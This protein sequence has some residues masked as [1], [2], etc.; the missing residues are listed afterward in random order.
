MQQAGERS[1]DL[2]VRRQIMRDWVMSHK[3][4]TVVGAIVVSI[5]IGAIG[6]AV[7]SGSGTVAAD[8]NCII[9]VDD[10]Y[11]GGGVAYVAANVT[12]SQCEDIDGDL[13]ADASG[14]GAG[15]YPYGQSTVPTGS[16]VA[17]SGTL[18]DPVTDNDVPVTVYGDGTVSDPITGARAPP[19]RGR[20]PVSTA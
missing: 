8:A 1:N 2:L 3:V 11:G 16:A 18:Q 12:Q 17:C 9:Q 10:V 5:I 6:S 7:G 13:G 4:A 19:L 20:R 14:V 15:M